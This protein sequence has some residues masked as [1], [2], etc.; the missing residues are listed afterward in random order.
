MRVYVDECGVHKYLVRE[1]GRAVCG[2]KIQ[3]VK[4]GRKF[5]KTNVV[6][7]RRRD[8][9]GKLVHISPLC[10]NHTANGTFFT[11]WF[12]QG[13]VKSVPKGATI[14]MDNA[15]HHPKKKL[16]N[17][18]RRHGVKLLFLPTYSPDL[19]PLEK[20]WANMKKALVDILPNMETLE[21]GVYWYFMKN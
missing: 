9:F 6:A 20:D 8:I 2:V 17:L 15:T 11:Q 18:A 19:N 10:F 7:A 13:L 4:R 1:F 16:F 14:I 3:D 21:D 12:R 5:S